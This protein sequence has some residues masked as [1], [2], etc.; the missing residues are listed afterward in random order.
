[1]EV[2][3]G[4]GQNQLGT[5]CAGTYTVTATDANGCTATANA[6][7]A[8]PALLTVTA[9]GTNASCNGVCD[10]TTSTIVVG[11]TTTYTY[12]WTGPT[13]IAGSAGSTLCAG[14][15]T[16]TVTDA[17]GCTATDSY[18][19]TEPTLLTVSVTGN[20]ASCNGICDGDATAVGAGGT[21]IITYQWDAPGGL[22][23]AATTTSTLCAGTAG[24]T[25]TDAN[26]CTETGSVVIAEPTVLTV[27]TTAVDASCNGV[28]DGDVTSAG[29]GGTAPYTYSWSVLGAGQNQIGS[30]C[31]ATYTVT[32][33]D[34]EG[35]T[36]TET[37]T[38][39]EP[40]VLTVT[41]AAVDASCSG[42]CDGD[43]TSL[44]AG[45]TAPITYSWSV[46]GAGQ[47]QLGTVCAGTYTVTATDA[48]G[49]TATAN[50][51][52]AEPALLTVTASGTNASCNGVCDGTTSTIVVGGTTTYTYAWTGPT[53]IA[54][55]A[56]STLC[57]GAYTVTVTDAEG[58]TAT[59][60]YTV[61]E[62][63]LLT[64][65][66][67]GNDASCNG[68]C[69]GDATAVGAGGTGI[70][71]YQWDAPGGLGT[72]ATTTS[73]LCAGTAGV[74]VTDANGCTETGSVV[75]AEPTVLTVTTTAVDASC[76]GVCDGDVTSAGAG[77]TAPYTYSWSVLGAGQ[78]QIGSVCA[79]TYTVTVTD[80][81][82][83]T[84]TE[85]AT[86][87]EPPVL[88]VTAAAVDASCSGVCDGDV[89]SLGAGGTAPITYSW[90]VL[91]A[92]Q[93]QLG[94]VCA[95]TYTV[96][97]T[98]ANGC[99][100]TAN[101]TV[102]EP[103]LLTVTASGTNA[104]CNGVC[105]GT[106]STIVVGGTTTYTYAWTGPTA[107]A[108]SAGSTLCAG[109]YTVTVTDAE[110]CTATDSYTVTEP[111]L[112]TVSVT[113]NDASCNGICDGD[114]T[115][116]GAGGTGIITYQWDAPGGL[117]TA[118]TTTSTLCAGTAGVTVTD[119]NGC[120][121][122][123][124][125]VI[126]EPTVLTVTT[127]AVDASCNGVCDGDVTSAGA[128][129]TAPY[130]YSWSVLGAGQNQIG[131]VCAATYTVTVTDAEGCTA[132][133]TATVGEPPVLTV[134]AAAVDASCSG[135]CDGDVT[136]LGAGGTAPITYSWSVLGAG[137][138]QLGTVCA[139]T[140]TVTATDANGCTATANA[141]VAEPALLTV[142]ASGT[143]ASCNGV[144]DGTTST[145]VV[146]GTT[147]YTYAWTGPTAIAGSAGSTLCA[148][149]YTVTVTDAEGCTATDS[150]TVTEP[151]LLTV[152]V[153]GNDA[154]CNG[155]CDGDATAV[156]AGGTGIITYQWDAPGG[157]GTAA[158][159]TST[160]CAGTAGVTVTDANGC[161]ETGSVV[162]AEP[163]VLTVTTTAVDAS[164]N[165]V[166]DGD[167]TSAGAGGTAPYTYSWS[168]LGAGQNQIGSVCAA[169]YTVTV[170]DAEGCTA[171]E[172]ATVGEPP[173]LTVTAA[174]VDASC[175]GVCDG[176]VTS[177]GAGGTAPIT[178]S[179][180]VLGAGQNQLGT[181]CAGT[182][183]VTATDANGCT[184]TANATV[185]EPALLTVTA[186]GTNASCNGVCDGTTSTIVVGGTT[187]YTYA[188]TGPTAIAGSAGSTLCAGAYTVTVTDAEGCTATDSY[189]VTEPTLLT[190]SVTGNDASC[191]GI[192]DGD[193]TAVGAGGTGIITY[194]WDAPG[195]LGTAATT[196][197]TLCAGTAGVTVTDAN[198]CTETGSVVIA[199]PT[200]L[201]A[202]NTSTAAAC[203]VSDGTADVLAAGGAGGYTYVWA[204]V[205]GTGQ[206]TTSVTGLAGGAYTVTITDANGCVLIENVN[207][208]NTSAPVGS[209]VM[210]SHVDILC[211]GNAT[212]VTEV[213]QVG[214]TPAYT[215]TWSPAPGGGQ[216]TATATGLS[217]GVYSVTITDAGG[218][219]DVVNVTITEP[220][221]LTAAITSSTD[222]LCA[223]VCDGTADVTVAGGT[224]VYTYSWTSGGTTANETAMC[225]GTETVTVTDA[226]G[227]I[228][229][230]DIT[231]T[232][233]ALLTA[234][235]VGTDP[236]CN[237]GTDGSADLTTSGGTGALT[238]LWD[239]GPA[240]TSEDVAGLAAG[241]YNVAVT[242]ANGC[243]ATDVVTVTEP[244]LIV[245]T[246]AF[247]AS[248]CGQANGEVSV[249][250]V[251]GTGAYTYLWDDA[252]ASTTASVTG[253]LAGT[254]NVTVTDA[255]GCSQT[256][257]A[258]ITDGASGTATAV[259]D[260]QV[261]CF[262]VCDGGATVTMTGGNPAFTYLWSNGETT[263]TATALC[264]GV[265]S[266]DV[267]D[268]LG[269]V[270]SATVTITEPAVLTAAITSS[271]DPLCATVCDGTA[272]VTVAGGT[273]V[274]TYSWTSGGTTA[275][276]TAM[277]A[278]TSNCNQ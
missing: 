138:N 127:T 102:A 199:E 184:A 64:V 180:S 27:T 223:T 243:T 241:T 83:C 183:T 151:T 19:V 233:P 158:T 97:A 121:E 204:P 252:S 45:G 11:G 258:T 88:T 218:C 245:L 112:L 28:C 264:V 244:T 85:T 81:E 149:A 217:V 175:S 253:L 1:M 9:S 198:G 236:L 70:I 41:A 257:P 61:T 208:S 100:A 157:L 42:V 56:G 221:V 191:N 161:T 190:V 46:L 227:C 251:G 13:A 118:A 20:D 188:W 73:T 209:E 60:S 43:V 203:G 228:T 214:G 29:A 74:T 93:N 150:Y 229:T 95:G 135:V 265:N 33:T 235:I 55:S 275:N 246:P 262:G 80:A 69:D 113:G 132:T 181:V 133:E 179:W 140:Y 141:T 213:T 165:G 68:I 147:T 202:T 87:G 144:C 103:A 90:S 196:T 256:V 94:T 96:T 174:A 155:I 272:D 261:S 237:A 177:L 108:G 167:V 248:T 269:C 82:G 23:T 242:D 231:L 160:L 193:A 134:T 240:S 91:G 270:A 276:E 166:C 38:V 18:T 3:L 106:T 220:A 232:D 197:S 207:V 110:G 37:A 72:A 115:A 226:N 77:G 62:P 122:T 6:T 5:V 76:N 22:G 182:Y 30:V 142:T 273:P 34:A 31:A 8:E 39:G 24:V 255:Q 163:T 17:E 123:G 50:A 277:C 21:G 129:G 186:S 25:V 66:V 247:V 54:G 206:G 168:V 152:S 136:S 148:G 107:I 92:G 86:V 239:D 105:D 170:T 178:Y 75:I 114:A 137:Q 119:A 274:Y 126:A 201:T 40:P 99:T 169:T 263:A 32:V 78:N 98:D 254:Y 230:A 238:Y 52:V 120:T 187:T 125:V 116:V 216:G 79:A 222:P 63:T 145:I 14:A 195:G 35:C 26:G 65:S 71:T 211:F 67:T 156:G 143:N 16:V 146:G 159:T 210:A 215:Y 59:D 249:S 111:T 49:C 200:A 53:A 48:N 10:G 212:G 172:T 36:A 15:Y 44:G 57:A 171:T 104:S 192:C 12:A 271:T 4:A 51:T 58:C 7:V 109:A 219:N 234:A 47:N 154:S 185:A 194:Q 128:G 2:V 84:A 266:V 89:T 130:T 267:T 260:N 278:G 224:P 117:G 124:S 189:T 162:I 139:G 164:C 173:V 225:A 250:A 101:A 153:T 131:S 205:P 176:D 259:V 268:A